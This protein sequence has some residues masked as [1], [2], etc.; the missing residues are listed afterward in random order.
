IAFIF[1]A[2]HN[3]LTAECTVKDQNV[4]QERRIIS[5]TQKGVRHGAMQQYFVNMHALHNAAL[6]QSTLP[7]HL[8]M[9]KP[10]FNNRVAKHQKFA[11]KVSSVNSKRR[12]ATVAKARDTR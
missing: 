5:L 2:Q 9:P 6:I 12:N 7:R 11:N 3:C 1:N 10:Y 8:S 4:H